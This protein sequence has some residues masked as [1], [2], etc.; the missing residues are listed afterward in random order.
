MNEVIRDPRELIQ[1]APMSRPQI[2][3]VALTGAL[4]AVD[5]FDLL[6]IT[7]VAPVLAK[8]FDVGSGALGLLLSSS[9]A[10]MLIGS[11]ILAP[12]ADVI[13]RR[14]IVLTSLAIM[15]VGMLVSALCHSIIELAIMRVFTGVGIGAMVAVINPIAVEFSNKRMRSFAI[16]MM[17]VGFPIGGMIGGPVAALLLRYYDWRA[18]F[19]F[20][21][22]IALLLFPFVIWRLPES[23][24][25]LLERRNE[26]TLT[27]INALLEKFGHTALTGLPPV[28]IKHRTPYAEIFRGSQLGITAQ[29]SAISFLTFLTIYFFLSWQPKILVDVGFDVSTA[30]SIA[31]ASSF[32]GACG[33]VIFGLLS[34]R[35][36]GRT[37]AVACILGLGVW[38]IVFGFVPASPAAL[39]ITAAMLAGA[40][41]ATAT[42]G[43]FVT[44][45]EA[46][47]PHV[48][49]T[50][51]GFMV[52]IG[53]LAS[54]ISPSLAGALFAL[55]GGRAGVCAAIGA[56]A[57]IGGVMLIRLSRHGPRHQPEKE[58]A[59]HRATLVP[60]GP[61]AS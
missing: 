58:G 28:T 24:S 21:G 56:C 22:A 1:N 40:G 25:F 13:G 32:A 57:V 27:R 34:R 35:F 45:A 41:V 11:F 14:P 19:L 43:L 12:V 8:Y 33:S 44:A 52:G 29:V 23:L 46:F 6:S 10:G 17:S 30:A 51:T 5:G 42:I 47:E 54:A 4:S 59:P 48:R 31:G 53:R 61:A 16:S 9:L 36:D 55:G 38:V 3:A 18:V 20:G 50:G 15:V 60:E 49:A 39:I 7:F 2:Y 26:S 37:L